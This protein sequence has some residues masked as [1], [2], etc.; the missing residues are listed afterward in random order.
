VISRP[1]EQAW[2]IRGASDLAGG[3]LELWEPTHAASQ[4]LP[5]A[6]KDGSYMFVARH[7]GECVD[8][9]ATQLVQADCSGGDD[10]AFRIVAQ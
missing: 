8:A 10:Q 6:R 9:A 4:W 7:S 1:T 5:V 2:A 3:K